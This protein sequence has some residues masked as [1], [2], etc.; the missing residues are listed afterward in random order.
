MSPSFVKVGSDPVEWGADVLGELSSDIEGAGPD[1][2]RMPRRSVTTGR[3]QRDTYRAVKSELR[4]LITSLVSDG[5]ARLPSEEDLS[6]ELEVSR[7]TIRSALLSLQKD[8]VIQ[9]IHGRGTFINRHAFG[10][11]ANISQDRPFADLL[12]ELGHQVTIR[13]DSI[14]IERLTPRVRERTGG[15]DSRACVIRRVFEASGK[16]AVF[17]VDYVP[18]GL[19]EYRSI[20]ELDGQ[21]SIFDFIRRYTRRQVRYS[22][23]EIVPLLPP[24]EVVQSL[25]VSEDNA[26]ILLQHTHIDD[27]DEPVAFTRAYVN[28]RFIRFSVVR[29]YTDS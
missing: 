2:S 24:K 19:L 10:I 12:A 21:K 6:A 25:R 22:V 14:R 28:D 8:G 5:H 18:L 26:L 16:P 29:S 3:V 7:A 20:D 11:R 17:A 13:T 27:S 9:R 4:R 23:A 15:R 1:S